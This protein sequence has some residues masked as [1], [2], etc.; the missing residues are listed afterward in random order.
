MARYRIEQGGRRKFV[1]YV[2]DGM[3]NDDWVTATK[4]HYGYRG[5]AHLQ[6]AWL[7]WVREGSPR[8]T[9]AA[10]YAPRDDR[11]S[12]QLV[13][14]RRRSRPTANLIHRENA[15]TSQAG[16]DSRD[17]ASRDVTSQVVAA[18]NTTPRAASAAAPANSVAA[19]ADNG[20]W[21]PSNLEEG[22]NRSAPL[23]ATNPFAD[24]LMADVEPTDARTHHQ[25]V[26]PQPYQQSRQVILEW[27]REER[28]ANAAPP[29]AS[30]RLTSDARMIPGHGGATMLR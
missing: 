15:R 5:L 24:T 30:A 14:D 9:V 28:G 23:D 6:N 4:E 12:I 29:D 19:V 20:G 7:D 18:Q 3:R 8:V 10:A 21:R 22:V 27:S 1:R 13:S 26:R 16:A 11:E 17:T 2:G 25:A